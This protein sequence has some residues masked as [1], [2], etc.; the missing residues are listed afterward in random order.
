MNHAIKVVQSSS[1][2]SNYSEIW[3]YVIYMCMPN[4][5]GDNIS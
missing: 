3:Q 1:I 5:V 4:H 2:L